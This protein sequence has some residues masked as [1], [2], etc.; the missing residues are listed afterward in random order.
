M[1]CGKY[2][3]SKIGIPVPQEITSTV[4]GLKMAEYNAL[5]DGL[6]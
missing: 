3:V 1:T 5:I 6:K 4:P 2:D